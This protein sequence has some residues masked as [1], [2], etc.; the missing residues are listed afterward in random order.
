MLETV[1]NRVNMRDIIIVVAMILCIAPVV[2]GKNG[3]KLFKLNLTFYKIDKDFL[4][5]YCLKM[6]LKSFSL[7]IF[8]QF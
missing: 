7:N 1:F 2:V 5:I 8:I 4:V 6:Q 3:F